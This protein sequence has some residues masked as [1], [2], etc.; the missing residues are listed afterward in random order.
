MS[1]VSV[2]MIDVLDR[3]AKIVESHGGSMLLSKISTSYR[4][5]HSRL[6]WEDLQL[7]G[8]R[9][10]YLLNLIKTSNRLSLTRNNLWV[11]CVEET[12]EMDET[13]TMEWKQS[14]G[15]H[16]C[17]GKTATKYLT[18][19][20]NSDEGGDIIFGITDDGRVVGDSTLTK[21][22]TRDAIRLK[23]DHI[24]AKSIEPAVDPSLV[25]VA[26]P[27]YDHKP[28]L[29]IAIKSG[30]RRALYRCSWGGSPVS[31]IRYN[32]SVH[33]MTMEQCDART[34]AINHGS[35]ERISTQLAAINEYLR[36]KDAMDTQAV[37][38]QYWEELM[39]T[40]DRPTTSCMMCWDGLNLMYLGVRKMLFD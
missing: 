10:S 28:C 31:F 9:K 2:S 21:R 24:M 8:P 17:F 37:E 35:P 5:L 29:R 3:I 19:F 40:V 32:A 25:E 14:V 16:S 22:A 33:I 18:A 26:F 7:K 12:K 36:K 38:D 1:S 13:A 27:T 20:L 23:I 39:T 6:I 34:R 11:S 4:Q 15:L 30:A